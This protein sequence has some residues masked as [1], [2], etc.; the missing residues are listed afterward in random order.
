V[1]LVGIG[2]YGTL[3]FSVGQR[4][5]EIGVRMALGAD[6]GAVVRLLLGEML[7]VVTAGVGAGILLS[8]LMG[9]TART[10][11]Y[12]AQTLRPEGA[13]AAVLLLAV[14]GL[15]ACSVPVLRAT[16]IDPARALR[17]D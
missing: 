9:R 15:A 12:A 8:W 17:I 7:P 3:A 2:M 1:L 4:T 16:R 11:F 13:I 10:L 6:T 5:R 14:V